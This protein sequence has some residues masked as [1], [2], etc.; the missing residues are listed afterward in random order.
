MLQ[1]MSKPTKWLVILLLVVLVSSFFSST[2]QTSFFSVK[3]DKISF[4]TE[5]GTLSGYLYTPRGVDDN[6]PAPA[7]V[8]THG[9]LNNAE[10]QMIGAIELSRRGFVVRAANPLM[11]MVIRLG[12]HQLHSASSHVLYMTL[13]NTCMIKISS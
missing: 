7:V 1:K 6:N 3:V 8:L 2:V 4:E 10:M 5:R 9:Y 12:K 11:T 13:F